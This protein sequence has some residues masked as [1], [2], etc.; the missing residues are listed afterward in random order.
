MGQF[1]IK[2]EKTISVT[3]DIVEIIANCSIEEFVTSNVKAIEKTKANLKET[4]SKL[5][6]KLK[7]IDGVLSIGITNL[8]YSENKNIFSNNNLGKFFGKKL[9]NEIIVRGTV[10]ITIKAKL[11]E[12]TI[13][14]VMQLLLD[15]VDIISIY[16]KV[17]VSDIEDKLTD[18]KAELCK[19]CRKD[20]ENIVA[21]LGSEI[22]G[23]DKIIYNSTGSFLSSKPTEYSINNS[24]LDW[25]N[26]DFGGLAEDDSLE[27]TIEDMQKINKEWVEG[28]VTTILE[29]DYPISDNITV[30]FNVK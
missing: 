21:C 16:D 25:G 8:V 7:E 15:N 3:P 29:R 9:E 5:R 23:I 6:I 22:M 1:E 10:T 26:D 28:F 17:S 12:E 11:E 19:K 2:G 13:K 18:L 24:S 4:V 30:V 14:S 20:A 27:V